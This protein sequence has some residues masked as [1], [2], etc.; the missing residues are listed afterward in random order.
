MYGFL[1]LYS[2]AK[3]NDDRFISEEARTWMPYFAY[4]GLSHMTSEETISRYAHKDLEPLNELKAVARTYM[5]HTM[6]E[7]AARFFHG[8]P[9]Y[10]EMLRVNYELL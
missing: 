9:G 2:L 5:H 6:T 7:R 4:A 8:L 10:E 3:F 1:A